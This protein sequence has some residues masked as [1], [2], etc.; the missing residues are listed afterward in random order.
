MQDSA[1]S[2]EAAH[3]VSNI[4]VNFTNT[5]QTTSGTRVQFFR[6]I[7]D[8]QLANL[9][10]IHQGHVLE[11]DPSTMNHNAGFQVAGM[12]GLD[13]LHT[14]TVHLDYRDGL[15]KLEP[16]LGDFAAGHKGKKANGAEQAEC[17]REDETERP[18]NSTVEVSVTG[19]LDS[20]H[21]KPGK[22]IWFKTMTG[23]NDPGCRIEEGAIIY[24]HVTAATASKD[25]SSSELSLAFDHAD[26][27]GHGKKEVPLQLIGLIGP[28]DA[29]QGIHD[30]LPTEV[31]GGARDIQ[32]V[33]S[34]TNGRD[35]NLNPGG[36]P[37]TV[38]P[39]IVLRMPKVKLEPQAGPGCSTRITSTNRSVQL[40]PGSELILLMRN[41]PKQP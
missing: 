15:V 12:L 37:N 4:T 27:T 6:E 18:R 3:S 26:C 7:F 5:E 34:G 17:P 33:V 10:T 25:A 40:G 28:P 30:A 23:W 21:L 29:S 20:G 2:S 16:N 22:E 38:H 35:D 9:P 14:M 13:A 32:S 41:L 19:A 39:G 36:R 11:I 1:M 24:G 8:L 31:S